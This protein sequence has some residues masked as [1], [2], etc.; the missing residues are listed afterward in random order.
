MALVIV[1]FDPKGNLWGHVRKSGP[2][3]LK[4]SPSTVNLDF[5]NIT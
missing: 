4:H 1:T 2:S 5:Y 3:L